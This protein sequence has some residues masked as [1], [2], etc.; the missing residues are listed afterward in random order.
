[1]AGEHGCAGK[2]LFVDLSSGKMR[3]V[4]TENY[5]ERF[6]GGKGI[7]AKIYWDEVS[8]EVGALDPENPVIFMTGPAAGIPGLS[9][10][11]WGMF[12]KSP[13]TTPER[14]YSSFLGGGWG[15]QLK[16]SGYDGVVIQG[17]S[18]AP[19]YLFVHDGAAEIRDASDLWGK[20]AVEVRDRIKGELGSTVGVVATGPAGDNLVSMATVL[21]DSDSCGTGFGAVMGSKRLKAIAVGG[22]RGKL[23]TANPEA[24]SGLVHHLRA[25]H[26]NKLMSLGG[27]KISPEPGTN[28]QRQICFGCLCGCD[29]I[30]YTSAD[31]DRGKLSCL[32][33]NFYKGY[34]RAYYGEPNEVTFHAARLC[35]KHGLDCK[36]IRGMIEWLSRCHQAGILT[37]QDTGLPLSTLGSREFI[38]TLVR[39]ISHREGF[40]DVLAGGIRRAAD[41]V[42]G[43]AEEMITDYIDK[44]EQL[45]TYGPRMYIATGL[46]YAMEPRQPYQECHV[47]TRMVMKWLHWL[48]G[49]E[50]AFMSGE[51]VRAIGKRFWGSELAFDFSTYEGKALTAKMIQDRVYAINCLI[52]CEKVWPVVDSEQSQDHVND[53]ALE[54]KILSA[55]TGREIDEAGFC[56]MGE[57]VFNLVRAIF[58]REGHRGRKD[59]KLSEFNFTIPIQSDT[60]NP[61]CLIMGRDCLPLSRKGMVVDR[62][63]FEDMLGEYY[64]LRGWD[65]STGLQ[66][67]AK[68]RELDLADIAECLEKKNLLIGGQIQ[69]ATV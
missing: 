28:Q 67:A 35:D 19:V 11:R 63:K 26:V 36:V 45:S 23:S 24:L 5:A 47:M 32:Q 62:G 51:V 33:S 48:R 30:R 13:A 42:G 69:P 59:D 31:G 60:N 37:D 14:F 57:R 2:I 1:M 44:A 22:K 52:L 68:L 53:P 18:A 8:P 29:R 40:G 55:I 56:K 4:L 20:N 43:G 15:A 9:G 16:F 38:E 50:G 6:V 3:D 46:F 54:A 41:A 65:F 64:L 66:T 39:K 49:L 10:S 12:G 21:A 27:W 17:K 61:E 58:V 34:A 25:L 7:A